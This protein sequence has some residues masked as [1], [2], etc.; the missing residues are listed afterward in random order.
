MN[1]NI[2]LLKCIIIYY[3]YNII[4]YYSNE[5]KIYIDEN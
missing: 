3:T 4:L 1:K 2:Q 5:I